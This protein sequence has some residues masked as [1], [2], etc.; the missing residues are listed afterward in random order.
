MDL[1]YYSVFFI[2]TWRSNVDSL[3]LAFDL[4]LIGAAATSSIS[5]VDELLGQAGPT[6]I[7]PARTRITITLTFPRVTS[8]VV[9][10]EEADATTL[11]SPSRQGVDQV[12][13]VLADT[14]SQFLGTVMQVLGVLAGTVSQVLG[15]LAARCRLLLKPG[16]PVGRLVLDRGRDVSELLV[17]LVGK[18]FY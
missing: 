12:L 9:G 7:T 10:R 14:V 3:S 5:V 6:P 13:G 18:C 2:G 16:I 11:D 15:V 4:P 8:V 1:I 17:L